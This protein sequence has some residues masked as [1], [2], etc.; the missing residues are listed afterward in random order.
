MRCRDCTDT[1]RDSYGTTG[2]HRLRIELG[3]GTS[4]DIRSL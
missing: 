3:C 4:D 2:C 1:I